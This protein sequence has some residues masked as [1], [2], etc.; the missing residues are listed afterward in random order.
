MTDFIDINHNETQVFLE[1]IYINSSIFLIS[2]L[3]VDIA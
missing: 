3:K 1:N 2:L